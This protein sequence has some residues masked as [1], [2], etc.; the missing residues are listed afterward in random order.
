GA[1][2]RPDAIGE[3]SAT[4]LVNGTN[5]GTISFEGMVRRE[6]VLDIDAALLRDGPNTVRLTGGGASHSIV[7]VDAVSARYTRSLAS[8]G[9]GAGFTAE[10]DGTVRL[11]GLTGA[12]ILVLDVSDPA[13][14]VR[15]QGL[16]EEV[17]G[18]GVAVRLAADAGARYVA[19]TSEGVRTPRLTVDYASDLRHA[20][21]AEYVVIAP[22]AVF[23][24]ARALVAH[25][26]AQGLS[27]ALVDLADVYDEF[28]FGT[29]DPHAIRAFLQ[30]ASEQWTTP[31]RYVVLA[32]TGS[33][34]YKNVLGL[35]GNL[36]PALM[37]NTD[38]GLYASDTA[39]ADFNDD[40]RPELLL[41]RLPVV[42]D[43]ELQAFVTRIAAY[44][45]NLDAQTDR[46]L[47]LSD[48]SDSRFDVATDALTALVN[49][50]SDAAAVEQLYRSNLSLDLTRTRLFE[51]LDEGV[52]WVNYTGHGALNALASDGLLT[53]ADVPTLSAAE[54]P[55][56]TTMTCTTSR[57]ELPG[58]TSFGEAM[59]NSETSIGVW[60]ASGLSAE[61]QA[62]PMLQGFTRALYGDARTVG[63]AIEGAYGALADNHGSARD[64]YAIYNLLGDPATQLKDRSPEFIIPPSEDAG[65]PGADAGSGRP[66]PTGD[67]S[68][69]VDLGGGTTT[70]PPGG[71]M[72]G[73]ACSAGSGTDGR[74]VWLLAL[75]VV[76]AGVRRRR[77]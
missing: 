21:G 39:F 36:V 61:E 4:V 52:F 38:N 63:E 76:A 34:D 42:S 64:M 48:G 47:F 23:S 13:A 9:S 50:L 65:T 62:Q 71:D 5:V 20:P 1:T 16:T 35:N 46:T 25:R 7:W 22:R 44:E 6:L 8:V 41:G 33:F 18:A 15:L 51:A 69:A 58:F 57:F 11:G 66:L 60:G 54:L 37:V 67:A 32:G 27:T 73:G 26:E 77:R 29:P 17:D 70:P 72:S 53:A 59:S 12:D 68:V 28:A 31:P 40:G 3:H 10:A 30:H 14:P 24:G 2:T 75:A 55:F 19:A 56:F 43:D 49:V 74:T 45:A